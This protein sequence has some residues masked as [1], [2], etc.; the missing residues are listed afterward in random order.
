MCSASVD[1]SATQDSS[2]DFQ[3][4]TPSPILMAHAPIERRSS[5]RL[6]QSASVKTASYGDSPPS[7]RR[8]CLVPLRWRTTRLVTSQ[9]TR[10]RLCPKR[11]SEL[12]A[13]PMSGRVLS[14]IHARATTS[15][16]YSR[17]AISSTSSFEV[18]QSS[19]ER[20]VPRVKGVATVVALVRLNRVRMESMNA[21]WD[22]EIVRV[23]RSRSSS[24]PSTQ[25]ASPKPVIPYFALTLT[26]R[27][28]SSFLEPIAT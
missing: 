21:S 7:V 1:E 18:G 20:E 25:L 27:A 6:P 5:W 17:F 26:A 13:H 11:A 24:M 9:W 28:V 8:H 12:V 10:P 2:L 22:I 14:V 19:A 3:L 4:T 23:G 15:S 16:I